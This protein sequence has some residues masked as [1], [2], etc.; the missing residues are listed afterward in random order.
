MRLGANRSVK[1]SCIKFS[2]F[3]LAMS[4]RF[5]I[6][7]IAARAVASAHGLSLSDFSRSESGLTI[8]VQGL[9]DLV[10]RHVDYGLGFAPFVGNVQFVEGRCIGASIGL[11]FGR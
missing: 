2:I 6:G 7:N 11:A 5:S 4:V 3:L 8:E 10:L 9:H 1:N